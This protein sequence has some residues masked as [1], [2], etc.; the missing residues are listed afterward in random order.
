V[1]PTDLARPDDE[2]LPSADGVEEIEWFPDG[3]RVV[4]RRGGGISGG[5][6]DVMSAQVGGTELRA[7]AATEAD[8]RTPSLSPDGRWLVYRSDGS[9]VVRSVSDGEA[10][11]QIASGDVRAPLWS[12]TGDEIFYRDEDLR[13]M[14]AVQVATDPTFAVVGRQH[15]F[16]TT[17]YRLEANSRAYDAT[18]DGQRFLMIR[19]QPSRGQLVWVQNFGEELKHLVPR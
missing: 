10:T 14:V 4:V 18:S 3:E 17:P 6:R 12:P 8:E 16:D 9:I 13:S 11:W 5:D 2:L 15:L 19:E 1:R 7:V